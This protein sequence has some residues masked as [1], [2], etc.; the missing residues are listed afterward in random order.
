MVAQ[1]LRVCALISPPF[2]GR[3]HGGAGTAPRGRTE[4]S[5]VSSP[6]RAGRPRQAWVALVAA[7]IAGASLLLTG[8]T[9]D[10]TA[11]AS[12]RDRQGSSGG[13]ETSAPPSG[14]RVAH[15]PAG[16]SGRHPGPSDPRQAVRWAADALAEYG[17]SRTR[18][19]MSMA[20]G[21]TRIAIEGEGGFDYG[22]GK[23]RL[24]V[25]LP[26]GTSGAEPGER[27]TVTELVVP[28]ALYMKNRGAGVPAGKWVRVDTTS[29]AD[30]NLITAGA[31]DP[32]SAAEL[33]RGAGRVTYAG[34][35][36]TAGGTVLRRYRGILD[37]TPPGFESCRLCLTRA[38]ITGLQPMLYEPDCWRLNPRRLFGD[39][40]PAF[41]R[42]N[43]MPHPF[44]LLA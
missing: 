8:C 14:S 34:K 23:G 27:R 42:L 7:L 37:L 16:S 38:F 43:V 33:L 6:G 18:T 36:R 11:V 26:E 21:G 28:G 22:T 2:A 20:S 13:T 3:R 40:P 29:L 44:M 30:G 25:R 39:G 4:T 10:G 1:W 41:E 32:V 24:T 17:T 15:G 9:D 19:S 12:D 31:T 5:A 35:V